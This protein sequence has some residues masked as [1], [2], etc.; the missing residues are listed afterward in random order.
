MSK[1]VCHSRDLHHRDAS[2]L[3]NNTVLPVEHNHGAQHWSVI[4]NLPVF[5]QMWHAFLCHGNKAGFPLQW[6]WL[7][8]GVT[9]THLCFIIRLGTRHMTLVQYC[10]IRPQTVTNNLQQ[11]QTGF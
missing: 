2:V 8:C 6:L 7:S 11:V 3:S 9:T 4:S 1:E 10:L 5:K